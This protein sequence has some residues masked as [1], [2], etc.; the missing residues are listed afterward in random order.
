MVLY[1][2]AP[3]NTWWSNT[4]YFFLTTQKKIIADHHMQHANA[5]DIVTTQLPRV[6]HI[7]WDSSE[8]KAPTVVKMHDYAY[9]RHSFRIWTEPPQ[10][11]KLYRIITGHAPMHVTSS[12][13]TCQEFHILSETAAKQNH[14]QW[15]QCMTKL[16]CDMNSEYGLKHHPWFTTAA[17][18][19]C[20]H[21]IWRSASQ[22]S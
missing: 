15:L 12:Q 16:V 18:L 7:E 22:H 11:K 6:Q 21:V 5:C 19:F 4:N 10:K 3:A 8:T 17:D 2:L 13:H 20:W 14:M 9:Q 1:R